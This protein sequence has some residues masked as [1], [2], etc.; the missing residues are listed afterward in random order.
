MRPSL[1]RTRWCCH[2]GR[3]IIQA[4]LTTHPSPTPSLNIS[5]SASHRSV[6][7]LP[8]ACGDTTP[9]PAGSAGMLLFGQLQLTYLVS[10]KR[11]RQTVSPQHWS[12]GVG[13][14]GNG[15]LPMRP[16]RVIVLRYLTLVLCTGV[17]L[18]REGSHRAHKYVWCLSVPCR[19]RRRS[20]NLVSKKIS[21]LFP[22]HSRKSL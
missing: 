9:V 16:L 21:R 7:R 20:I 15:P 13:A 8:F 4:H 11:P 12:V 5:F 19:I 17:G 18:D 3:E 2:R 22:I 10:A 14:L 1:V 6:R